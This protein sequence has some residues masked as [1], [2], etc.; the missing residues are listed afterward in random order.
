MKER[1]SIHDVGPVAYPA[2]DAESTNNDP[3][4]V[5]GH[6]WL[7]LL[8]LVIVLS[9]GVPLLFHLF[10]LVIESLP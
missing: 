2:Y 5:R 6:S 10:A 3:I 8:L 4:P 9:L 1:C 7:D